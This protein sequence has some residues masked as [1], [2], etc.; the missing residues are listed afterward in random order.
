[1]LGIKA[2]DSFTTKYLASIYWAIATMGT[3]G[4]GDI[5]PV[6]DAERFFTIL[7]MLSGS[8]MYASIFG[9]INALIQSFD[10]EYSERSTR[11]NAVLHFCESNQ[12]QPAVRDRLI[13]HIEAAWNLRKGRSPQGVLDDLP[14]SVRSELLVHV[15]SGR[16]KKPVQK[17]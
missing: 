16:L 17:N 4:Y 5:H 1:M 9:N 2:T 3:V 8:V 10:E 6:T 11:I 12:L 14:S 13:E 15:Y 7:T